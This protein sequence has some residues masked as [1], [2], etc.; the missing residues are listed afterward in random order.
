[1]TCGGLGIGGGGV[2]CGSGGGAVNLDAKELMYLASEEQEKFLPELRKSL[3]AGGFDKEAYLALSQ[4][5]QRQL[6]QATSLEH[7]QLISL[8]DRDRQFDAEK[9]IAE[10]E[11]FWRWCLLDVHP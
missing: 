5:E 3:L 7:K 8:L 2:D 9:L 6:A 10:Q 1:M 4:A 11:Y